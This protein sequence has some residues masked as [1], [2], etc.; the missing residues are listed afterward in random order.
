V[1]ATNGS[2]ES[3]PSNIVDERALKPGSLGYESG[4][5]DIPEI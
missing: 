5:S 4:S 3:A 2:G 1:T